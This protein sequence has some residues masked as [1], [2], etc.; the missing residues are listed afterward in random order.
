MEKNQLFKTIKSKEEEIK[1]EFNNNNR[2]YKLLKIEECFQ[3]MIFQFEMTIITLITKEN[4]NE[5]IEK[6]IISLNK[7]LNLKKS[8]KIESFDEHHRFVSC[9]TDPELYRNILEIILKE[10]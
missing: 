2:I 10:E 3:G 9:D 1:N 4:Y 5:L 8:I 6:T 7:I